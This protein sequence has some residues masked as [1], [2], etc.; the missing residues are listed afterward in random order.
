MAL[1]VK[2]RVKETC[3]GTSGDMALA[4]A[5]SG[6]I[7]FDADATFDGDTTYYA[8]EDV[9][10]TK[11]E[12]GLG[13]LSADSTVLTRTTILATQ[14]SFTDTTRQT[15][16]GGAHTIFCTYPAGK[17]VYLTSTGN[18]SHTV[19]ISSE[20]N[21]TAGTGIA[22][23][24]DTLSLTQD[25]VDDYV[26]NLL[27]AGS[28]I[29]L[30]YDDTAGTLTI[31]SVNTTYTAG[32]GL[33]LS[34]TAFALDLKANGG[35]VIESGELAI[36]L[37]A[38]SITGT[39]AIAD[40][41]TGDTTLDNLITL[42][43][44]TTGNYVATIADSGGGT[45]TVANS[46]SETAAV[47]LDIADNS[48]DSAHYVDGS[49]DNAHIA[50]DAID[51]E[52]YV[53][54]S[55]DNAHLANDS[56]SYGGISLALGESDATPAFNLTDATGLPI[57]AGT[58]GT[59]SIGRGG[60]GATSF[61]DKAVVITQDGSCSSGGHLTEAACED[62][63]ETWTGNSALQTVAMTTNG[64]L[65]IGGANG[66]AVATLLAGTNITIT[67][68]DGGISI[69]A[70]SKLTTE[71]VQDIVGAMVSGNTETDIN[72][73]Y[74]DSDGTLDFAIDIA[75]ENMN[76]LASGDLT[77]KDILVYDTSVE[78]WNHVQCT[79]VAGGDVSFSWDEIGTDGVINISDTQYVTV[80][81]V[82]KGG[83]GETS[84]E[85]A[86]AAL[87]EASDLGVAN[88]GTGQSTLDNLIT[89]GSHTTGD[90]VAT[91]T[92]GTGITSTGATSGESIAHSISTDASQTHVTAL[93]TIATGV[94]AATDVAV[95][96][97]GTGQST[98]N[99]LITLGTHTTGNYVAT[100]TGGT[101]ITSSGGTSGETIA[102][103]ISTDASQTHVTG[104]GTIATGT[105]AATDV[106][107]AHGGTGASS[108]G[109][110]RTNLGLGSAA[111]RDA[112]DSLTDGANLPD[113]AAIKAYGD[114]NWAGGSG[115]IT[116]VV[117]GAGLT[118]GATSGSATLDIGAGTGIDVATDAISV[119]VSDFMTNGANNYVLTATGTDAM[120]AEANFQF[121]G[122]D[123]LITS[124]SDGKPVL[125]LKTTHTTKTSSGEL[126][127]LKDAADTEDGEVLG[128]ITFY[129]EDGGNNNT[130][131][132]KIV[133]EISESD[134]GDEAGKLSFYVAESD[135]TTTALTAG[136]ILEGEHATDGEIDVTVG[137]GAASTV[138]IPGHIDLAGDIDVDGTLE[139]DAI[140]LGGTALGS[141]YSLI[142]GS[143]S[144]L[145]VGTI[146]TGTWQGT[147]IATA[148]IADDAITGAKIA[149]FDDSLAATTTHFLIAD[150]TDYS[151]FALSGDVTC[152]NAGAVTVAADAITYAKIQNVS[153][154]ERILGRV[155]GAD[156]VIEELTKAQVLT[157]ANVEDGANN[158]TLPSASVTVV[159][160][161][162]LATTG[163]TTT[164]T[165]TA[166]A[167]TPAGVQA[168]IDALID[169]APGALDT[170][171]ELAAAI[172]DDASYASTITTALGLK[173]TL[174]SPTFTGTVAIPNVADLEAAVVANTAKAT[175]VSTNLATT[176]STT[177]AIITS[178]DGTDAT[179]PVATTS[180]GGVM[181]KAI[182]D[183]HT[184]N[185]AKDTNVVT[186]LSKTVSGTGYSIDSSDGDNIALSLADTDNWGLMSDEMF[187]TLGALVTN[188]STALS[189]GTVDATSYGITSDGGS[190]DIVLAQA[191]TS[192]A[193]VLSAAKWDEIVA[194]TAK[195]TNA[196][197]TGDVTGSTAL[198]IATD[199][200]DIAMLSATG[201]ASSSTFLRGDNSWVT[202]TDTNTM[203]SGFTV[204]ATTD[205][206]ATTITQG[207][208]LFFAAGTGITCETTADGTVTISSTVTDTNTTYTAGTL[209]DLSST[210]FNVDLSEASAAVMAAA[211]E[212]IFLDNDDGSAAKRESL[213]DLL[214][215]IAGTVG[216]TGLDRS[217]G[218]LVVTDLHPV[219]VSGSANQLLT[220]DGDG[221]VTSEANLTFDGSTLTTN[222]GIVRKVATKVD[223]N[224]TMTATDHIILV[225]TT[226]SDRTITLPAASADNIGQEYT[227]KKIDEGV[228]V[229]NIVPATTAGYG[230]D[231]IDEYDTKF[232]LYAQHD[233]V[234]FVCGPG[235]ATAGDE[236]WWIIAQKLKPHRITI[237][238]SSAQSIA[239]GGWRHVEFQDTDAG[240][241][242]CTFSTSTDKI[243]IARPGRYL[244][245]AKLGMDSSD[246]RAH[247]LGVVKNQDGTTIDAADILPELYA[248]ES[249]GETGSFNSAAATVT[250]AIGDTLNLLAH[251][252]STCSTAVSVE[253]VETIITVTEIIS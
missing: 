229:V 186:N 106:A 155:S 253:R 34:G 40:G 194:N 228:G 138:T 80:V 60:T 205:N 33:D 247:F 149:L 152:N 32:N 145:T 35:A 73:T 6:F 141:L 54:G 123:A 161:V 62:A 181:S 29:G 78:K 114:A 192:V 165:D 107:V 175:N 231:D 246:N 184:A 16:S 8:L 245:S 99:D 202:P 91:L 139:A 96:H 57:V 248:M 172:N 226:A 2:D 64:G 66:P 219:G 121:D 55:I 93:G 215:T 144:I 167:V 61:A 58:T 251:V 88:G 189:T 12:V 217:G 116:A 42:G 15:F 109:D 21:L 52:H 140:T 159:G 132:A 207:E 50:D 134:E 147:A 10:G 222:S 151:S 170:L 237:R 143:S 36:D 188:V 102:H 37:A 233:S 9:D 48:I 70:D 46:G 208:D 209:L 111:T 117:A 232:V 203:G 195:V 100:L 118:G 98:L 68:S 128:Q 223:V 234:T 158:Y 153:A 171:N 39:L 122:N 7:A 86:R 22:L 20:T 241:L 180:V 213:S 131:F 67:N 104:L 157:F 214:D 45:I 74:E 235:D 182:F 174:A 230:P 81:P 150:G 65:L 176:T 199:A 127:F 89:L 190:D 92:G 110:A 204:S 108:A 168:A 243:T 249:G 24:G 82:S 125:T 154:D 224:Y 101:G 120:N 23:T 56:V 115:D 95:A 137:A 85:N 210:T 3:T 51:S 113:G 242:G 238:N 17:A 41:G 28:F 83:T 183:E 166:R 201:T 25:T 27:T 240:S 220:D 76:D 177:T 97:G 11:W 191:T 185:V 69:A 59:L 87:F 133:A 216:T 90:Y 239:S 160:G 75:I 119:D 79:G 187:D 212:F 13:T 126:Q 164:G 94:W 49:I 31:S 130:A 105:W 178:S 179:I 71:E 211:D 148:Y 227:I 14:V 30:T 44:H 193:G 124:S 38:S 77:N 197:H 218:T 136:L 250:L 4:G 63:G 142:A 129:G 236:Q 53:D 26:D 43:D 225:D 173:A 135:S 200:V 221:T 252:D 198:T 84:I 19:D 163:E 72:V 146:G 5:V 112:E 1:V 47:T 156:G 206:N 169:G 196:T 18:L 162:E 103:S 244:V